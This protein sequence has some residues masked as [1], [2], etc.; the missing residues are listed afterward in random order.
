MVTA[1]LS[2]ALLAASLAL[3]TPRRWAWCLVVWVLGTV[4][5]AWWSQ[6]WPAIH[7][8]HR[9]Y[10]LDES[11]IEIRSGV[12]WRVVMRVPRSR[13]QHTD[14]VQGPLERRHGLGRLVIYTAGT[15]H[16]KVELPGLAHDAA[17]T[18]R[19]QL[20]P[21]QAADAV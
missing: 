18:I 1:A 7:Y 19:D 9:S 2:V 3:L 20:L 16:S 15:L 5:M 8:R 21:R 12:V 4:I 11:G 10:R 14:V 6:R 13:V 17:L